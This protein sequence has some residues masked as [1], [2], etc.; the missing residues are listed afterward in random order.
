MQTGYTKQEMMVALSLYSLVTA[1]STYMATSI[2]CDLYKYYD[3]ISATD[4]AT[5]ITAGL[6]YSLVSALFAYPAFRVAKDVCHDHLFREGKV[7]TLFNRIQKSLI[8]VVNGADHS[9][10]FRV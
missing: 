5:A 10:N 8:N 4:R 9:A 2:G 3:K 7:K 6:L 1:S